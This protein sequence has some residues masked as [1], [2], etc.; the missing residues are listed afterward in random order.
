MEKKRYGS[1]AT[2]ARAGR[3]GGA[4]R[5]EDRGE[6]EE[7]YPSETRGGIRA[8]DGGKMDQRRMTFIPAMHPPPSLPPS[9]PSQLDVL[10]STPQNMH[11]AGPGMKRR[12]PR[13]QQ[14]RAYHTAPW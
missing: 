13:W 5:W 7:E 11:P 12:S 3:R 8:L 6:Q 14:R 9:T 1:G 10:Y 4:R 2:K